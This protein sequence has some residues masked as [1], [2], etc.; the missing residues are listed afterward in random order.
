VYLVDLPARSKYT[1]FIYTLGATF[2]DTPWTPVP[3][4]TSNSFVVQY[5]I[6]RPIGSASG[7][8]I[9]CNTSSFEFAISVTLQAIGSTTTT[10]VILP[11]SQQTPWG[12]T[13]TLTTRAYDGV[14]LNWSM[15]SLLPL[16]FLWFPSA[17]L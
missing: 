5:D 8:T 9:P 10:T 2:P 7:F 14:S 11:T 6:L 1:T 13:W 3:R 16:C 4:L 17:F 15:S 12:L